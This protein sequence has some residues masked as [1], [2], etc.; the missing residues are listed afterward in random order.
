MTWQKHLR[1]HGYA[2]FPGLTP[3][4][5]VKSARKAI[6]RDL[7]ANFDPNRE[8]EYSSRSYCP[9]ITASADIMNLFVRSP[10]Y[11]IVDELLGIGQGTLAE[12]I[13]AARAQE[14]LSA[15]ALTGLY[16]GTP[17]AAYQNQLFNQ[18][19]TRA[20]ILGNPRDIGQSLQM[21]GYTPQQS[22]DWLDQTPLVM[23]LRN[24]QAASTPLKGLFG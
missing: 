3:G 17:T 22:T 16:N 10:I 24:Q 20:N 7:A 2:H 13:R 9:E 8:E 21:L 12:Q 15:G 19:V 4:P 1:T 14:G 5:L 23:A 6:D 11:G 18:G